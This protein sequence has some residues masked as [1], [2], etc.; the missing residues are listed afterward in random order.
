MQYAGLIYDE[1]AHYLDHLGPFCAWMGWPLIICEETVADLARRYYPDLKV[2]QRN[3]WEVKLPRYT[4]ACDSFPLVQAAFPNQTTEVIWLPHGNSDKGWNTPFFEA[5]QKETLAL[6]YG[7]KMIDFFKAKG[8]P[9]KT[10]QIGNFRWH[11]YQKHKA[12]YQ[13]CMDEFLP[14]R[15]Y[16][17]YAPTWD[18]GENGNSFW[19]AFPRLACSLGKTDRLLVK[20]HPNTLRRF[21]ME[22]EI[23]QGRYEKQE[24][25]TFLPEFPPIY[26][27]LSRCKAYIGDMS[28]IGYDFLTFDKPLFFLNANP[29]LYL[30]HCGTAI[31][32]ESFAFSCTD[33]LSTQ[34][35]AAYAYTFSSEPDWEAKIHALCGV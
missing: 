7:P 13:Q 22:V 25:I 26:P 3:S 21:A 10:V 15:E 9:L 30:T 28:S 4:V 11:Y 33:A 31:E 19:K 20:L 32:P 5:L 14:E 17:L 35:K 8:V 29:S 12:F 18:D 2:V 24:N 1:S 27:L 23:L 34:R 6:V 16:I